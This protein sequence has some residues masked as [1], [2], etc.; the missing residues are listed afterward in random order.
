[1]DHSYK[2]DEDG[3]EDEQDYTSIKHVNIKD[4]NRS[5]VDEDSMRRHEL[6]RGSD[7]DYERRISF[8]RQNGQDDANASGR[9]QLYIK[10]GNTEILRLITRGR[11]EDGDGNIYVNVPRA[12]NYIMIDNGGKEILM[13]RFIE[14][15][16][17]GKQIIREHYQ[18][19]PNTTFIQTLPNEVREPNAQQQ[20]IQGQQQSQS[21]LQPSE[22]Q[23][24]Q[25][26]VSTHSIIQQELEMS[27][28][29][30]NELLRAILLE[31]QELEEKFKQEE[32]ALETQSLPCHSLTQ[33]AQTQTDCEIAVQTDPLSDPSFSKTTLSRRRTRS[34]NDDSV[35]EEDYEYVR[36]SPPNSPNGVYMIKR[37]RTHR[38]NKS[39]HKENDRPVN[40]RKSVTV[41]SVKRNIRTPIE[42]ENE[43]RKTPHLRSS[44]QKGRDDERGCMRA[45]DDGVS[46]VR[47]KTSKEMKYY[48]Q[49]SDGSENEVIMHKNYYSADSLD[50]FE[51]NHGHFDGQSFPPTPA[52]RD[53]KRD[54]SE[55]GSI[56]TRFADSEEHK[57]HKRAAPRP[58][59]K[60]KV[61]SRHFGEQDA[62]ETKAVP[63]Y[64][65]WYVKNKESTRS[66]HSLERDKKG[67]SRKISKSSKSSEDSSSK[68]KPEPYPRSKDTPTKEGSRFLKEDI[69][70]AKKVETKTSRADI[71]N[72]PLLQHSEHRYEYEYH[73]QSKEPP[74]KLP[75]YLY[76]NTPP[77]QSQEDN[78][79]VKK[80][81]PQA[82]PIK[83]NEV[84][85][86]TTTIKIPIG[87]NGSPG[88]TGSNEKVNITTTTVTT[89]TQQNNNEDDHDSGIAMNSLLMG[90]RNKKSD[91]KSIFT[92]AYDDVQIKR[93]QSD[94]DQSPPF[95]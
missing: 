50:D 12:P 94:T 32:Q 79:D 55:R 26:A 61:K 28:K 34:E 59:D 91:K 18:V 24:M 72:H 19:I 11:A 63:R 21:N 31:K 47:K 82:S 48:I 51:G 15:Q 17:N 36:Y 90:K 66:Q 41:D 1:M 42:E 37:K 56:K 35:S 58:P 70:R 13:R 87:K 29:Q 49:D 38:K 60:P 52:V 80:F 71:A 6:D 8:K 77:N 95:S 43:D 93:I 53:R 75:H 85:K 64:M 2:Y 39:K 62:P 57:P 78:Q 40:H 3:G 20:Q 46:N 88:G 76:P 73:A 14:D 74:T 4:Q 7:I 92:I 86:T 67:L 30:Q 23:D 68:P 65:E 84:S 25:P 69:E 9:D 81:K 83:E 54:K 89:T 44:R 22:N 27:L 5:R 10:E 33:A 45:N 16:A